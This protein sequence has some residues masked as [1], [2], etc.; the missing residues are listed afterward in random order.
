MVIISDFFIQKRRKI[1]AYFIS[2]DCIGCGAC[3][4]SCPVEAIRELDGNFVIDEGKCIDCGSCKEGC[5]VDAPQQ[6]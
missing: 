3:E 5:P 4:E 1:M 6:R 2:D